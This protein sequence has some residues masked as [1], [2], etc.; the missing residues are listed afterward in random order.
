M[1]ILKY[2]IVKAWFGDLKDGVR[3]GGPDDPRVS[4]IFVEAETVHY[5]KKDTATP[6]QIWNIAKG[7]FTGEPP[8]VSAERNLDTQELKHAREVNQLDNAVVG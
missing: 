8:K 5:S 3:D 1:E 7:I 4:L 2:S 6:V